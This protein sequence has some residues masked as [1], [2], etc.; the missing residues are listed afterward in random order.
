VNPYFLSMNFIV[1]KDLLSEADRG[2]AFSVEDSRK[3]KN[4]LYR[5]SRIRVLI[6]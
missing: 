3:L 5:W 1:L 4:F 6:K 2:I